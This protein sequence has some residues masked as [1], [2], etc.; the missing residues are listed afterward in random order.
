MKSGRGK[1]YPN[2]KSSLVDKRGLVCDD[3]TG[4]PVISDRPPPKKQRRVVLDRD[5]AEE[6]SDI[7]DY[8][9]DEAD[10]AKKI[11]G[12]SMDCKDDS[13]R[14]RPLTWRYSVKTNEGEFRECY[15][16][17]VEQSKTLTQIAKSLVERQVPPPTD[18]AIS[19]L[20][21]AATVYM[22]KACA[23]VPAPAPDPGVQA[24]LALAGEYFKSKVGGSASANHGD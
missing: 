24:L 7:E 13:T 8:S 1:R 12:S 2:G 15:E 18:P 10:E 20:A 22:E 19:A 5:I 4:S 23:P 9:Y 21:K 14:A 16:A 11:I 17:I 6:D 3:A